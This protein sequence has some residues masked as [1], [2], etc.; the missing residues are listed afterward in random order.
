MPVLTTRAFWC[1]AWTSRSRAQG[2]PRASESVWRATVVPQLRARKRSRAPTAGSPPRVGGSAPT[3][4]ARMPAAPSPSQSSFLQL[5][6]QEARESFGGAAR[7]VTK[8][9][10]DVKELESIAK[11]KK[12]PLL[13]W[14]SALGV[15]SRH[16]GW[17]TPRV[18]GPRRLV[19][20]MSMAWPYGNVCS[21]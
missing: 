11:D 9:V 7:V 18:F 13:L 6:L 3:T 15:C 20:L 17:K 2:R 14:S 1:R 19:R 5:Q 4:R 8:C 21:A 12:G 10:G 16:E